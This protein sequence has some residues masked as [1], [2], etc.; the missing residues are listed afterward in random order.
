M[1]LIEVKGFVCERCSHKWISRENSTHVPIVC[2][3]CHSPYWNIPRKNK[4]K[5][6]KK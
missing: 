6:A 1:G 4:L 5:G 2:P 3:K